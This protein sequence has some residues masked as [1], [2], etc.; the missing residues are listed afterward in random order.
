MHRYLTAP[1][2]WTLLFLAAVTPSCF[3]PQ[4][5]NVSCDM[6]NPDCPPGFACD[7]DS[8]MCV[9]RENI[10]C[11]ADESYQTEDLTETFA[12]VDDSGGAADPLRW[13]YW[14]EGLLSDP[15]NLD[16]L[17]IGIY[18]DSGVFEWQGGIAPG[19]YEIAGPELDYM[20]CGLCVSILTNVSDDGRT[21]GGTY[22]ATGGTMELTAVSPNIAGHLTNVTFEH[23]DSSFEPHPDGCRSEVTKASFEVPA[24]PPM[25]RAPAP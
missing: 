19:V 8:F 24:P 6:L 10:I 23:V 5:Q 3:D 1:P 16:I 11:F 21:D 15:P 14:V 17:Q 9:S 2:T 13:D 20:S 7:A 22:L 25:S 12:I 4:Y 18:G